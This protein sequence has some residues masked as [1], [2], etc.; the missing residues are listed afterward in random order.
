MKFVPPLV[1][2]VLLCATAARSEEQKDPFQASVV[3]RYVICSGMCMFIPRKTETNVEIQR[4]AYL[5]FV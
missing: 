5:A 3:K 4:Q 1:A 2:A